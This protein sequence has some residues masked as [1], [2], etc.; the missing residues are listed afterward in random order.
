MAMEGDV[1]LT[2]FNVLSMEWMKEPAIGAIACRRNGTSFHGSLIHDF[3]VLILIV[4]EQESREDSMEH[5]M[6][7]DTTCQILHVHLKQ[8]RRWIIDGE[9]SDLVNYLL[10]GDILW[11]T[12]HK[13][14]LLRQEI[15]AFEGT[16]REQK[17]FHEFAAFLN[18]YVLAKRCM[19]EGQSLDAYHRVLQALHHWACIELIDR[20]ILPTV[21]VWQEVQMVNKGVYKLYEELTLSIETVEQRVELVLLACEFSV[22]SKMADCSVLLFRILRSRREPW[23]IQELINHPELIHVKFELPLVLRKL[24]YRS[25]IKEIAKSGSKATYY[26]DKPNE[27]RYCSY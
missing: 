25:F 20:G 27:L 24:V 22:M 8:L 18:H 9:R 23:S 13:I 10:E 11:E 7:G 14:Q 4:Y 16:L 6:L 26:N 21:N 15:M 2:K 19:K 12:D 5:A 1:Q 17:L 3:G